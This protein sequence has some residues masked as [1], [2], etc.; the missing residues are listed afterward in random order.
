MNIVFSYLKA[1]LAKDTTA[2]VNVADYNPSFNN[3][4]FARRI[5]DIKLTT[6]EYKCRC[7]NKKSELAKIKIC[8]YKLLSEKLGMIEQR[9]T[10]HDKDLRSA[11]FEV[12]NK[13]YYNGIKTNK[14]FSNSNL[15]GVD[16]SRALLEGSRFINSDL[17]KAKIRINDADFSNAKLDGAEIKFNLG[18]ID[19]KFMDKRLI[20]TPDEKT[21]F[22]TL[23]SIDDKYSDIKIKLVKQLIKEV[24]YSNNEYANL[25]HIDS[26]LDYIFSKEYYLEDKEIQNSVKYLL[27]KLIFTKNS[28]EKIE[29][30][31]V[32]LYLDIISRSFNDQ[33][34]NDFILK[35]NGKFIKL[36]ATSI[37]HK[38]I[39]IQEKSR[40]LYD[41]Y[42][43]LERVKPFFEKNEFSNDEK[44]DWD[45]EGDNNNLIIINENKTIV[46]SYKELNKMLFADTTKVDTQWN[47]FSLY[48]NKDYQAVNRIGYYNLFNN[49]FRIFKDNY[50]VF[51]LNEKFSRLA[52]NFG[53]Y[54]KQF[55][56][57]FIGN[58]IQNKDKLVD[59][60]EQSK[61]IE[62][63]KELL[64]LPNNNA[65]M[66]SL[67]EQHYQQICDIFGLENLNDKE[68]SKYLLSLAIIF[69]KYTSSD[70]FGMGNKSPQVLRFY[71]YALMRKANELNERLM[72]YDFN[73][74]ASELLGGNRELTGTSNIFSLMYGYGEKY[75]API[76]NKM[77]PPHWK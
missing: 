62:V 46:T 21:L 40:A 27:D 58:P 60:K 1:H 31:Y 66:T 45:S 69:L 25:R 2:A 8:K 52:S 3:L 32:S 12:L 55:Y 54:S 37:Y 30:K 48:I 41:K 6:A 20:D 71:V 16:L 59:N 72:G 38:D 53:D 18:C 63:F 26:F 57:A 36:M 49:D 67:K 50:N 7:K 19:K 73:D 70:V 43:K 29:P 5:L 4:S 10:Y 75:C 28:K 13:Y 56:S 65:L 74:F 34:E 24:R 47:S 61:L 14:N 39:T 33:G 77:M 51:V 44:V 17:S 64:D 23:R 22:H 11:N 68:K 15:T 9:E 35:N 76:F 42:L